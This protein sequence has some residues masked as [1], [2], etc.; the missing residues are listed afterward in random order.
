[1]FSKSC[2]LTP[3]EI[4]EKET[5]SGNHIGSNAVVLSVLR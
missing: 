2:T 3:H 4:E 1:M 5:V